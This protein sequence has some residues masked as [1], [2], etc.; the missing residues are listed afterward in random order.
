[1]RRRPLLIDDQSSLSRLTTLFE[2]HNV[3]ELDYLI[4]SPV[5]AE[6]FDAFTR[7]T[8]AATSRP[9]KVKQITGDDEAQAFHDAKLVHGTWYLRPM[10]GE[11]ELQ[12]QP[13]GA[14]SAGSLRALV[15]RLTVDFPSE[16]AFDVVET[17]AD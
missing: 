12:L 4:A 1:M 7:T 6:S 17:F 9:D 3:E 11:D 15:E 14:V 10:Y 8:R 16:Y 5:V 2:A 13:D